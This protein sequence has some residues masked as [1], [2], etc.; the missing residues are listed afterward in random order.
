VTAPVAARPRRLPLVPTPLDDEPIASWLRRVAADNRTTV[1]ELVDRLPR[2]EGLG[3]GWLHVE[4]GPDTR[5]ALN[6]LTGVPPDRLDA[7]V[8]ARYDSV[9]VDLAAA[10]RSAAGPLRHV[11]RHGH[12]CVPDSHFCP[13]CLRERSGAWRIEW[14]TAFAFVCPR[15]RRVLL[16]RCAACGTRPGLGRGERT[17]RDPLR[18]GAAL[19][20]EA[21][22][23]CRAPLLEGGICTADLADAAPGPVASAQVLDAQERLLTS[24]R[25]QWV[26]LRGRGLAPR[27]Y[28]HAIG[29][30]IN[31]VLTCVEPGELPTPAALSGAFAE[32]CERRAETRRDREPRRSAGTPWTRI[33]RDASL[34]AAVVP[35]AV[36]LAAASDRRQRRLLAPVIARLR[37][38]DTTVRAH[39]VLHRFDLPSDLRASIGSLLDQG[40]TRSHRLGLAPRVMPA[41]PW[42][43]PSRVP[44]ALWA[45]VYDEW[46]AE[47]LPG[48]RQDHGRLFTSMA[49]LRMTSCPS[50]SSAADALGITP[51]LGV[52]SV[53]HMTRKLEAT[54]NGATFADRV[55]DL[56][57]QLTA[58]D[59]WVDWTERRA[60]LSYMV[61]LPPRV[62]DMVAYRARLP[63]GPLQRPLPRRA[64]AAWIWIEAS[65]SVFK[66]SPAHLDGLRRHDYDRVASRYLDPARPTLH[67]VISE[68]YLDGQPV[69]TTPRLA[70]RD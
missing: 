14:K 44:Q 27:E 23:C 46:F 43:P 52:R 26:E 36:Q 66:S 21:V 13:A 34:A 48:W 10:R 9:A 19:A 29:E 24:L 49:L 69:T 39:E 42:P 51:Y 50:F 70:A 12:A 45:A 17:S 33:R 2:A 56:A 61:E 54:G 68:R 60:R 11:A 47:L 55:R 25:G 31:L 53:S 35:A 65:S 20:A 4:A 62:M 16:S 8:L 37:R 38:G 59:L 67:T 22:T 3:V 64:V 5:A 30:V 58:A 6:V 28:V 57:E 1:A 18:S 41:E 7:M 32:H 15:H 40:S 63:V